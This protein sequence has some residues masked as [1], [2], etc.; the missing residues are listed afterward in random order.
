[1]PTQFEVVQRDGICII[2]NR[3]YFYASKTRPLNR[4]CG[5]KVVNFDREFQYRPYNSDFGPLDVAM[6][7]QYILKM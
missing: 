7:T 3:L 1:M 6:M 2:Q 5:M 4:A